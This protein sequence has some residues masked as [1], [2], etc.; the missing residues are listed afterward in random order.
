MRS[1]LELILVVF[2]TVVY[3][4]STDSSEPMTRRP[5]AGNTSAARPADPTKPPAHPQ[6]PST[7]PRPAVKPPMPPPKKPDRKVAVDDE[8]DGTEV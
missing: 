5:A 7:K 3:D 8:G 4:R 1:S 2:L 6:P